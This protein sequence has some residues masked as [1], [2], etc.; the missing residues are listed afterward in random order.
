LIKKVKLE[1]RETRSS[2][3][4]GDAAIEDEENGRS[5]RPNI[6]SASPAGEE[7]LVS[8]LSSFTFLIWSGQLL[9]WRQKSVFQRRSVDDEEGDNYEGEDDGE[10]RGVR[11]SFPDDIANVEAYERLV[12]HMSI[13][14]DAWAESRVELTP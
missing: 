10:S 13:G 2:S 6:T 12:L 3:P 5:Q 4:A 11:S 14:L 8:L 9:A 7:L 1:R